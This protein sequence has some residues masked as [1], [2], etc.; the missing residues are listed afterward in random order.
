MFMNFQILPEG[1]RTGQKMRVLAPEFARNIQ[2]H[3]YNVKLDS[4]TVMFIVACCGAHGMVQD[5]NGCTAWTDLD[6]F[7]SLPQMP[8]VPLDLPPVTHA[9]QLFF[10]QGGSTFEVGTKWDQ[11]LDTSKC[12]HSRLRM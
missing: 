8:Q 3:A 10:T 5:F 7:R 12:T 4:G 6:G 2:T 1:C 9:V 11:K